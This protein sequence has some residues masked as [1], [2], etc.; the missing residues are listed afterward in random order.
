MKITMTKKVMTGMNKPNNQKPSPYVVFGA[1]KDNAD[2]AFIGFKSENMS[3]YEVHICEC[4]GDHKIGDS[5]MVQ[6]VDITGEYFRMFFC[7]RE[8]LR[9][10]IKVLQKIDDNMWPD[11][12]LEKMKVSE[13]S[14]D[15]QKAMKMLCKNLTSEA[16]IKLCHVLNKEKTKGK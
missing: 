3:G 1:N 13:E 10:M 6:N 15:I 5:G 4:E 9:A 12:L 8:S 16:Q 2:K 14:T 7:N 11:E